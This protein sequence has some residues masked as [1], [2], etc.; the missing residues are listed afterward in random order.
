MPEELTKTPEAKG[1]KLTTIILV[2]LPIMVFLISLCL[3]RY[4][5]SPGTTLNILASHIFPID[6][7]W[8]SIEESVIINI[9]L[10]RLILAMLVGAG[11]AISGAGFQ[12]IFGNPLVSP[13]ILGVAAGAGFGAALGILLSGQMFMIQGLAV[14]FGIIAVVITYM[15]SRMENGTP[16]FMLVLS[17]VIVGALFQA[18]I[19]LIKYVADPED[20]LPTIVYWLMGSLSGASYDDLMIGVPLI[21]GGI[22]ILLL[23]RW[24]INVLSLDEDEAKALG[25]NVERSRWIIIV[26]A[27]LI[28][29][30]SVSLCGI[31]GWVGL[32]IPHIGRMLVGPNH[33]KLLPVCV[34]LGSF[35]LLIIDN[36]ART[37]TAAEIPLS[38]LTAIVGA[39]FFA[40]L[41]RKTGGKWS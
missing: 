40:Y 17:G 39:P 16:L 25:I 41:L 20:I 37:A 27:T 4:V 34:S 38:I 28:T 29:A 21:L 26:A 33:K 9:R 5:V 11:L 30:V 35:Y 10:P 18:L 7:T 14:A 23:M 15:I 3:G 36:I 6:Q 2:L 1:G 22:I 8:S 32:V 19:S 12:G 24:R 31:I 13:Q